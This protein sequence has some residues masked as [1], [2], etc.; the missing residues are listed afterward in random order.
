MANILH[1]IWQMAKQKRAQ[2]TY[3]IICNATKKCEEEIEEV[4]AEI[5]PMMRQIRKAFSDD[6]IAALFELSAE[7]IKKLD[8][9]QMAAMKP[10]G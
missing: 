7:E 10:S 2:K 5:E 3:E 4:D 8:F 6:H 1:T 9:Q